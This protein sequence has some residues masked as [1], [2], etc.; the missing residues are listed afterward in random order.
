VTRFGDQNFCLLF[1]ILYHTSYLTCIP[2]GYCSKV[3]LMYF[4]QKDLE[5]SFLQKL[6]TKMTLTIM[7]KGIR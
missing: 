3:N 6:M 2:G 7:G 5:F 4:R 1:D